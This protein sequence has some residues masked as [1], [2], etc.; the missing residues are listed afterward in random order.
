M[1]SQDRVPI[2][3]FF[4]GPNRTALRGDELIREIILPKPKPSARMA[5]TKFG[6]RNAMAISVVSVAVLVEMERGSL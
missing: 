5:Y 4:L 1:A 3:E 6:L 2:H